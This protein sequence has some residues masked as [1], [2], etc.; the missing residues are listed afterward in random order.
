M[1]GQRQ[2]HLTNEERKALNSLKKDSS[3]FYQQIKTEQ[4]DTK[5]IK[6]K[7]KLNGQ[8]PDILERK[9]LTEERKKK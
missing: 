5:N 7:S 1:D 9:D 8:T 3:L 6:Q 4:L 2:N